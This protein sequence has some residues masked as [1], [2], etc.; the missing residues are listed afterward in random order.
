MQTELKFASFKLRFLAKLI[1]MTF[2][3]SMQV[4]FLMLILMAI[5]AFRLNMLED[6]GNFNQGLVVEYGL[7]KTDFAK[8]FEL[9][10]KL[11]VSCDFKEQKYKNACYKLNEFNKM[12]VLINLS[13]SFILWICYTILPSASKMQG[14]L[15]KYLIGIKIGQENGDKITF[16]QAFARE[17]F[18][19][20]EMLFTLIFVFFT[21]IKPI[22]STMQ[23]I[24]PLEGL[25]MNWNPKK[26]ALHD[27][28]AQT[29]VFS[30]KM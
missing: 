6:I 27:R 3:F 29:F 25:M 5:F 22:L 9:S 7:E 21:P 19:F 14:T 10:Q 30:K 4:F 15:G 11:A 16:F 12:V 23:I 2:L 13:L 24:I 1:D 28:L 26:Q 18:V 17:I 8:S 20:L